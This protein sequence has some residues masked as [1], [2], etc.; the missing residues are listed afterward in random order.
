MDPPP[1]LVGRAALTRYE[2]P[3]MAASPAPA[4]GQRR[5]PCRLVHMPGLC[6]RT[7]SARRR[8][9]LRCR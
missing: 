1:V 7:R 5:R 9:G 8:R 2:L 4:F 3:R 6:L